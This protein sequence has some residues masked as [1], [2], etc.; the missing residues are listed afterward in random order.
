MLIHV[1]TYFNVSH[2]SDLSWACLSMDYQWGGCSTR[3]PFFSLLRSANVGR[4]W[5]YQA[6]EQAGPMVMAS[7]D[8]ASINLTIGNCSFTVDLPIP[9]GGYFH[10]YVSLRVIHLLYKYIFY[11]TMCTVHEIYFHY[12]CIVQ[13]LLLL[14]SFDI[15]FG[16]AILDS[17][18][19]RT[20]L[21]LSDS[22]QQ[23]IATLSVQ[24]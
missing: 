5:S 10:S 16:V 24:P 19:Q 15:S 20:S 22:S 7:Q 9:N 3:R 1:T 11:R 2:C 6:A 14:L 13:I 4:I 23:C 12:L 8:L 18:H 17:P 21:R